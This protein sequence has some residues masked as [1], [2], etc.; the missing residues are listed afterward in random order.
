MKKNN[1][2]I[3]NGDEDFNEWQANFMVVIVTLATVLGIPATELTNLNNL[4]T[5][6]N[7]AWT[8][9]GKG[10]KTTRT[11]QQTK[12]KTI[13]RN[14]YEKALR[15]FIKRWVTNNLTATADQKIA[16]RVTIADNTRSFKSA[17][18]TKP[19]CTGKESSEHLVVDIDVR[20]ENSPLSRKRP[21]E[22]KEYEVWG[23]VF[24]PGTVVPSAIPVSGFTYQKSSTR[25]DAKFVFAE[26]STVGTFAFRLR[27]KNSKG[28]TGPWSD[29]YT[30]LIS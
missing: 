10:H 12:T 11:S 18:S 9:G 13:A 30:V 25:H 23:E 28:E 1:D 19:V 17:P 24:M 8:A 21:D 2:Y 6:W 7:T 15:N 4:K 26:G 29:V 5:A 14:N 3:P 16:L 22:Y 27:W 20:D